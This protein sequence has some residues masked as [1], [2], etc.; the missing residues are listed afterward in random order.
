MVN[1]FWGISGILTVTERSVSKNSGYL[2]SRWTSSVYFL[3]LRSGEF[4]LTLHMQKVAPITL[5][6]GSPLLGFVPFWRGI[7]ISLFIFDTFRLLTPSL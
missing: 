5:G 7:E 1:L 3:S 4:I 2:S 6:P